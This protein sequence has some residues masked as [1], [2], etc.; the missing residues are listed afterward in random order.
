MRDDHTSAAHAAETSGRPQLLLVKTELQSWL[1]KKYCDDAELLPM[2]FAHNIVRRMRAIEVGACWVLSEGSFKVTLEEKALRTALLNEAK[3]GVAR[4]RGIGG[5][6]QKTPALAAAPS[7]PMAMAAARRDIFVEGQEQGDSQHHLMSMYELMEGKEV[8]GR[9]VWQMNVLLAGGQ[10]YFIHYGSSKKW[11]ISNRESMEAGKAAG[12]MRAASNAF[13]PDQI[14]ITTPWQVDDGTAWV[15]AP[16]VRTRKCS[17]KEKRAAAE[18][19][20]QERQQ[21]M[22]AARGVRDIRVEGQQQGDRLDFLMGVYTLVEG[23]EVN[24]RGVWQQH[25]RVHAHQEVQAIAFMYY[26]S[27]KDWF[28]GDR[29]DMEAGKAAGWM[30]VASTAPTPDQITKTWQVDDGTAWVEA[31]KVMIYPGLTCFDA[32]KLATSI[33]DIRGVGT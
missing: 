22:A 30:K 21:A 27:N 10:E 2:L 33:I 13:T 26:G 1:G 19:Q 25:Q 17:A 9:G 23:K 14:T 8:N 12:W 7:L 28:I 24:A 29:A 31:P 16:K 4:A 18:R 5:A 3:A 32:G 11:Y 6:L 20:E 15:E